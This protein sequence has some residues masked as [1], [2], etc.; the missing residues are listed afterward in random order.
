MLGQIAEVAPL[1]LAP[2]P[3]GERGTDVA[4]RQAQG[5][6]RIFGNT[7]LFPVRAE[8]VEAQQCVCATRSVT[9]EN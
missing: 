6:R 3:P 2:L 5:E 1:N 8:P 7:D 9:G 4:L